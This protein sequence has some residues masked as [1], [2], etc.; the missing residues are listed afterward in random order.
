MYKKCE[1]ILNKLEIENVEN[2]KDIIN[3]ESDKQ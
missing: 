2:F 1:E 3:K